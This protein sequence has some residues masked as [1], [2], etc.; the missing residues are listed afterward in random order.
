MSTE[1]AQPAN[2]SPVALTAP[3][4]AAAVPATAAPA[5]APQPGDPALMLGRETSI[6]EFNRRVLAQALRADVPLLDRKS[7]V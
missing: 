5:A 1:P 2:D 6:L 7:V 3:V 4:D